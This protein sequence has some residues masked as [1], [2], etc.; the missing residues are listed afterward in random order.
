MVL[1][2]IKLYYC[3][4][5]IFNSIYLISFLKKYSGSS[6]VYILFFSFL[7]ILGVG[8]NNVKKINLYLFVIL[9]VVTISEY[10]T[11]RM[12][13]FYFYEIPGEVI[14]ILYD[15]NIDEIKNNFY[16][17]FKEWVG[18]ILIVLNILMLFSLKKSV[19]K[20][21]FK[22]FLQIMFIFLFFY[23]IITLL[24]VK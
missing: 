16:F 5:F 14:N 18:I 15:T 11:K 23:F 10:F 17:S 1:R 8:S 19:E 21:V 22:V 13:S 12:T 9:L 2:N 7:L 24:R 6:L 4:L 3:I 20:T